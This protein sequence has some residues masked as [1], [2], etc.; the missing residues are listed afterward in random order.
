LE[1]ATAKSVFCDGVGFVY[2]EY[3]HNG[4]D[5]GYRADLT[6]FLLQ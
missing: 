6:G 4:Q 3:L 5:Y 2:L 1:E